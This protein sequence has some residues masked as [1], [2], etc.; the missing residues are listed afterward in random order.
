MLIRPYAKKDREP[1]IAIFDSNCPKFFDESERSMFLLWLDHQGDA[2]INYKSP[3]YTNA[4]ADAYY[5]IEIPN[6]GVIACAGFY[7]LKV[8]KETRLAWGMIHS[9]FHQKGFG[10][11]MYKHRRK[12]I[13]QHWPHYLITLGT[14]Q[15]TFGFYQKMG[16]QVKAIFKDGY[17]IGL[18][19]YDMED[20]KMN[21]V[22]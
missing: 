20:S 5:V 18:D 10:T 12:K 14:S 7:I 22:I 13:K 8:V 2:S 19:R 1:C 16:M 15:H 11:L 3:T 9:D 6:T 17:G 4:E 21:D